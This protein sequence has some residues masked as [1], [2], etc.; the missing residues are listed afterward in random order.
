M[1]IWKL[2]EDNW[3]NV[4]IWNNEIIR[5]FKICVLDSRKI[6]EITYNNGRKDLVN[7]FRQVLDYVECYSILSNE[8][9]K[10][11]DFVNLYKNGCVKETDYILR[12]YEKFI[13]EV[14]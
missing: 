2:K 3:F 9:F 10:L 4:S 7:V 12:K 8:S 5:D 14:K 6:Y 1:N 11:C 13:E